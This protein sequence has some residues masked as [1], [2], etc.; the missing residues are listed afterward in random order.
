MGKTMA[1]QTAADYAS[2]R[3]DKDEWGPDD[4]EVHAPWEAATPLVDSGARE[5][6]ENGFMREPDAG[7]PDLSYLFTLQGL[8][9]VPPELIARI[10]RHYY[11]GGLKYS[12]DNWK[13]GTDERSLARNLR[14]LARH[15]FQ[16]FRQEQD[17]DHLAAIV[18]NLI[19]FEINSTV[20]LEDV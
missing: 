10:A 9:L 13:K 20:G 11:N 5:I 7:K 12:P 14:S 18:W 2:M 8:D 15:L 16:W 17:E 4:N 19:T 6:A 1:D 3:V